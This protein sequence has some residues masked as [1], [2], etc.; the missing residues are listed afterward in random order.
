[1]VMRYE[2]KYIVD[3]SM[4]EKL[5]QMMRPFVAMDEFALLDKTP[6][7]T[8]R[9]IYF[10]TPN[11][12]FYTEKI[13]GVPNRKKLRI[14]GYN[15]PWVNKDVFLEIKRKHRIPMTKNRAKTTYVNMLEILGGEKD[16]YDAFEGRSEKTQDSAQKFM[17]NLKSGNL[18]PVVLV[19]YDRL[20]YHS[21]ADKTIRITHDMNLRSM[22][23]P[24]LDDLYSDDLKSVMDGKFILEVKFNK[25]YPT[26]MRKIVNTLNLKQCSAS[27]YCMCI[28]NHAM[29]PD[30]H[31]Y[32][33][34]SEAAL[35]HKNR[36]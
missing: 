29:L 8:V 12:H 19:T 10:D 23:L 36:A 3:L 13:E 27:K 5:T 22:P 24:T 35:F 2:F 32:R 28:E 17:Y 26:W 1:M 34:L 18:Q 7:Y 33:I 14:R 4:H 31:Q 20:P 6:G 16:L 21:I 9:S 11:L 25:K 30:K 15:K